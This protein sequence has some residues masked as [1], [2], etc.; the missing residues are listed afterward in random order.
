[1]T[2]LTPIL[3]IL[4]WPFFFVPACMADHTQN[5]QHFTIGVE[6]IDFFPLFSYEASSQQYKGLSRDI[7]DLFA[8]SKDYIFI[9]KAL[10]VKRLFSDFLSKK[11]DFKFPDSPK[12][13][14][15]LKAKHTINY[16][17]KVITLNETIMVRP[18]N[19]NIKSSSLK[20]L[21]V[22]RGFT[23]W[24][25]MSDIHSGKMSLTE[26]STP[27][28]LLKMVMMNRIDGALIDISVA[29]YHLKKQKKPGFLVPNN[30]LVKQKG[31]YYMSSILHPKII[32]EFDRFLITEKLD[33]QKLKD[34]YGL[35]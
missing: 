34:R 29:N 1:M 11:L 33:F 8:K 23:P 14:Q 32:Q 4:L 27:F 30:A 26:V 12:W 3:T 2:K 16:T 28:S 18:A 25:F 35:S 15:K 10:P 6:Q 17:Q 22:I 7:L 9:Y 13:Q 20:R 19:N 21:G 31:I 24:K 5:N